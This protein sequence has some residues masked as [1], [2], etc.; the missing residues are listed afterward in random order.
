MNNTVEMKELINKYP[1]YGEKLFIKGYL[2]TTENNLDLH[3]Y[4]F[5]DNWIKKEFDY[6][7]DGSKLNVYYHKKE[8][9]YIYNEDQISITLLGHAYNPFNMSYIEDD[10]L[11]ECLDAYKQGE[12]HFFDKISELTGIHLIV[13]NDNGRLLVVQDCGGMESCYYGELSK[14]IYIFSHPQ[15]LGDILKLKTDPL[16]NKLINNRFFSIGG[17]YLPGNLSPY[18]EF[19]RLGPNTFVSYDNTFKLNRF[20][21][22]KSHL[23]IGTEDYEKTIKEISNLIRN[24]I[25]LSTLKWNK[26]AISLTGGV[27]SKTTL[28]S[29]NGL[30]DKFH[31]YSFYS[32][33]QEVEDAKAAN[34]ICTNIGL[35]HKIYPIPETNEEIKDYEILKRIINH[36][37]SYIGKIKDNEIR[38]FIYLSEHND[39]D[40]ELKSWISEVGRAM[41]QKKYGVKLPEIL[42]PRHYSIFQTRYFGSPKLLNHSDSNYKEYLKEIKLDN[43]LFNYEHSDMFYWEFRFG[44]WG[45][46]VV[47][48]QN[49]F[50][51]DVTMP[52][53]NRKL[54]DMFLWFPHDFRK[55]DMVNKEII[56]YSNSD[57]T[58]MDINI[59]NDYLGGKRIFIEKIYYYY[60]T[61]LYRN[62]E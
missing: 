15:L 53:N 27:D 33:P 46:K 23:E 2:I 31:Y 11:K 1:Q 3:T 37:T 55:N 58:D 18:K 22:N 16:I 57:I 41:W 60:R 61:L 9:C 25:H 56:K 38:K 21:P 17:S 34:E 52:M 35:N 39:F 10:I 49:I 47:T 45:S 28:A 29:A 20:F 40:V 42:T 4:P 54:I 50:G 6:L 14:D 48:T 32:K 30:Y 19:R 26:P 59:H 51:H 8:T 12:N 43:P 44:S 5:N 7:Q 24:N 13:V 62:K 36:N